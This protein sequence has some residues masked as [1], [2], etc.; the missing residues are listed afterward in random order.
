MSEGP[1]YDLWY[2]AEIPGRGEFVRLALEAGATAYRDRAR[3]EGSET[4]ARDLETRSGQRPFAPPYLVAGDLC[5]AQTA[6]ILLFLGERHGL[7]PADPG[8]RSFA[9]QLQL[10]V[11]DIVAE[12]HDVHHPVAVG[13]YYRDQ[14]A[15]A[16]RAAKAFRDERIPK[17]LGYFEAVLSDRGP[18][19]LGNDWSYPDLS[20]FQLV[21]GLDYAFPRRMKTLAGGLSRVLALRDRVREMPEL[22]DYLASERRIPFNEDG[23]FRHYPELDAE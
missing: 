13:L 17:Y 5:L 21:E 8:G 19:L 9:H 6:N 14:K 2:W 12:A 3:E 10:T 11:A 4:L 20:L 15:E 22:A 16:A 1:P 18:W 23:I 7:A